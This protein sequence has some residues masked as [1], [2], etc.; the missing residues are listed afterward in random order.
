MKR[1]SATDWLM[2]VK[3]LGTVVCWQG[4]QLHTLGGWNSRLASGGATENADFLSLSFSKSLALV[5][6]GFFPMRESTLNAEEFCMLG[7]DRCV[8]FKGCVCFAVKVRPAWFIWTGNWKRAFID[9]MWSFTRYYLRTL[10]IINI[11]YYSESS[12]VNKGY[13]Y[14][15][16]DTFETVD[17]NCS[18]PGVK[19]V[20]YCRQLDFIFKSY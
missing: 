6:R 8:L 20:I 4:W 17:Y 7:C 16:F 18:I 15:I 13:Y 2:A 11:V 3:P 10:K 5:S 14:S 12:F 1:G 19:S 9:M